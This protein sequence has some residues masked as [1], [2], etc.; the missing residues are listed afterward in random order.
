M[1]AIDSSDAREK[2][3]RFDMDGMLQKRD[4]MP[5]F[6]I[7]DGYTEITWFQEEVRR[8]MDRRFPGGTPDDRQKQ[9]EYEMDIIIQMGFPGYFL[10]VA[11]FIMWAKTQGI[12]VGPGRGSA[13]GSIVAYALGITD[14]DPI[15]HGLIFERF[16]NPERISMPDVDIDFDERRRVEVIRYVTEKYGAD[17]VAMIGTYGLIKAKSPIK[18][19]RR[20]R[21]RGGVTHHPGLLR[22]APLPRETTSS[23]ICRIASPYRMEAKVLRSCWQWRNYPPGHDGGG[24]RADAEVLLKAAGRQ[25]L[26][27]HRRT[28]SC[29]P[30][31]TGCRR[32][33]G[34]PGGAVA[35]PVAFG[36]RLCAARRTGTSCG[37]C[38]TRRDGSECAS[39]TGGGCWTRTPTRFWSTSICTAPRRWSRRSAGGPRWRGG[40]GLRRKLPER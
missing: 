38:G 8:G 33:R 26:A 4:R 14:L 28:P 10:V 20:T 18:P 13:A 25:V 40:G 7:P 2:G 19:R 31:G 32:R 21:D 30:E 37:W 35:G 27:G 16:L 29:R 15:P 11:D 6:D 5:M 23:L 36:C 24:A 22:T 3:L 9:A 12:A 17:K 1:Y 39:G 34:G